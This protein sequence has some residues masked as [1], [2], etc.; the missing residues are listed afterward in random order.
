MQHR[1]LSSFRRSGQSTLLV[2]VAALAP[3]LDDP[4]FVVN[5]VVTVRAHWDQVVGPVD[6]VC[7]LSIR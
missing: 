4:A 1:I 2:P 5:L 7:R 3:K 6:L